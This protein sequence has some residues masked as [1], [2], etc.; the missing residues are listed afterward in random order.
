[1]VTPGFSRRNE[2]TTLVYRIV[3][4]SG[5]GNHDCCHYSQIV[6]FNTVQNH[7]FYQ[8]KESISRAC[9]ESELLTRMVP[10]SEENEGRLCNLE[11]TELV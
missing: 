6:I 3:K 5:G 8:I 4:E 7:Q 10:F 2:C 1:M 9:S 11:S